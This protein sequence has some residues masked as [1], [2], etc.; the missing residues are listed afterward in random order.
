VKDLSFELCELCVMF[1]VYG[2]NVFNVGYIIFCSNAAEILCLL[3]L[4]CSNVAE[5]ICLVVVENFII[6]CS[7]YFS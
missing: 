6:F 5:I 3:C 2:Y 7:N 4:L 1:D